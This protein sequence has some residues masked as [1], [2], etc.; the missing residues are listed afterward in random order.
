MIK[1]KLT[2]V[3]CAGF[4]ATA[5]LGTTASAAGRLDYE[6]YQLPRFQGNNYT[7]THQKENSREYITNEVEK[8]DGTNEATFWAAD[9]KS[10]NDPISEDYYQKEGNRS[11]ILFTTTG[12]DEAGD[13]VCMGMENSTWSINPAYASGWVNFH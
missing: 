5:L 11:K 6:S 2:R 8:L 12:F 4:L 1:K 13:E 3:L 9:P 7:G 10:D